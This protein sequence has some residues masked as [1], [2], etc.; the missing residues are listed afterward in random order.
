MKTPKRIRNHVNPLS[1]RKEVSFDGFSNTKN[2]IVDI[3]SYRGEFAQKLLEHFRKDKN[4]ILFEI[5]KPFYNYLKELFSE[6]KNVAVFDG[7]A[8]RNLKS[9]LISSIENGIHIEKIFINFPDP[10]FKEKHKKRRV[11]NENFLNDI[12]NW[13]PKE[14]EIVFQTDQKPL[15]KETKKLIKEVGNFKV[16]KLWKPYWGIRTYWEEMKIA[17]KKRI[18]RMRINAK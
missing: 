9:V 12:K 13:L 18:Y 2:I 6:N 15:F 1:D 5:R 8:A 4:L 10:W 3:G 7:D 16:K 14:T 17:E 11:V